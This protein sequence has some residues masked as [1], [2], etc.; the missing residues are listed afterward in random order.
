MDAH[1]DE[2]TP[3]L[4]EWSSWQL[5]L[6]R[7]RVLRS[8]FRASREKKKPVDNPGT[9]TKLSVPK[10]ESLSPRSLKTES[11]DYVRN[12]VGPVR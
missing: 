2:S 10:G 1:D 9:L 7:H 8:S 5:S 12:H 11:Y 6:N 4:S 3:I